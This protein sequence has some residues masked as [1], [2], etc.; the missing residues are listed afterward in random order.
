MIKKFNELE[1]NKKMLVII[2]I[3]IVLILLIVLLT[4][5][6]NG[7]DKYRNIKE[8]SK[9]DFVYTIESKE[10]GKFFSYVPHVNI[11]DS[12]SINDDIDSYVSDFT[13]KE[14]IRLSYNYEVNGRVLSLVIKTVDY[15]TEDIPNIY[16]KTYNIDLKTKELISDEELLGNFNFTYDDVNSSIEKQFEF[17]YTDLINE[18]YFDE[19]EC[20]Y[21]CFLENRD[22]EDYMDDISFYI[23]KG[24]LVVYKPFVIHSIIG[25]ERYFKEEN[26]KFVISK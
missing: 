25:E 1:D 6:K 24:N 18:E 8:N 17:W 26:F 5:L 11:K 10:E 7:T 21:D 15:D 19:E 9:K 14:M 16:F 20:D 2:I 13:N 23:E 22:V 3:A 4:V 12:K